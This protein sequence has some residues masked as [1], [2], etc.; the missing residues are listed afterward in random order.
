MRTRCHSRRP[1]KALPHCGAR[2]SFPGPVRSFFRQPSLTTPQ[3]ARRCVVKWD[4][5]R[6][7]RMPAPDDSRG[8]P[9]KLSRVW[10]F[11]APF[12]SRAYSYPGV[13]TPLFLRG[14]PFGAKPFASTKSHAEPN[15]YGL[16]L[17]DL[18]APQL[19]TNLRRSPSNKL[20][21]SKRRAIPYSGRVQGV[22]I[23]D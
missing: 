2:Q 5:D 9:P 20:A 6:R 16:S 18:H 3:T 21:L 4:G 11:P 7:T 15:D 19:T 14:G 13:N 8:A 23:C 12:G 10:D 22:L 1:I 17:N